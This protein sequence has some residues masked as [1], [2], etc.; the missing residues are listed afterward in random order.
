MLKAARCATR[1][2]GSK[3]PTLLAQ[4]LEHSVADTGNDDRPMTPK[5]ALEIN[6]KWRPKLRAMLDRQHN[7]AIAELDQALATARDIEGDLFHI[8]AAGMEGCGNEHVTPELLAYLLLT[9][10]HALRTDAPDA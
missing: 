6:A 9:I 7:H 2:R 3:T 1:C 8:A 4:G 5:E 10:S